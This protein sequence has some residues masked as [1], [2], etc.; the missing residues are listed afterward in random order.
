MST[1]TGSTQ[2]FRSCGSCGQSWPTW[3]SFVFDP[4]LRLLGMQVVDNLPQANL[5]VFEH[6]CGSSVS[7]LASRLRFLLPDHRKLHLPSLFGSDS[8]QEHCRVLENLALCDRPCIN[9]R[10]RRLAL[11]LHEM[12]E[13]RR[14]S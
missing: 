12:R 11:L 2:P 7:V 9:A 6:R 1:K 10:D 13:T 14:N 5:V 4:D 3:E 8:C